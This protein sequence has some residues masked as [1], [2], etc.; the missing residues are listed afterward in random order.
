MARTPR[1]SCASS[2]PPRL[3][4]STSTAGTAFDDSAPSSFSSTYTA[5][6]SDKFHLVVTFK[7]DKWDEYDL[8]FVT[9][10]TGTMVVHRFDKNA[11]KRTDAGSFS[12]ESTGP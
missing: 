12:V 7:A 11:L 9:G 2:T 1:R 4:F 5:N 3:V 6:G 10:A 8:T